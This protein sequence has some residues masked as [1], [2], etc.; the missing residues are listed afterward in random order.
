MLNA[1]AFQNEKEQRDFDAGEIIFEE[2]SEGDVMYAVLEGKIELS[3]HDIL[4]DTLS[5]GDIFGE[6]ALIDNTTRSATAKA[7]TAVKVAVINRSRFLWLV[8][9]TP[10]FAIQI[11]SVMDGR[12]RKLDRAISGA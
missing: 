1:G 12:I 9:E 5:K 6:M 2:G 11:M 3:S 4:F 8:Q 7:K 10:M